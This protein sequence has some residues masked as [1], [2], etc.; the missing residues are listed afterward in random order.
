VHALSGDTK[1]TLF[2][3]A[4]STATAT[5]TLFTVT[6][7]GNVGIGTS[8]PSS[9][10]SLQATLPTIS[11]YDSGSNTNDTIFNTSGQ[12]AFNA[13]SLNS[14]AFQQGGL[15]R[16]RIAVGG[17][18][19]IGT[20]SPKSKL[21]VNGDI[22]TDGLPP[23][24]SGCGTLP[25]TTVGDTDTAGMVTEGTIATGCTITFNVAKTNIPFCTVVDQSGLVFSY[26]VSGTA[27]VVT[28]VGALSGTVLNYQCVQ[29]NL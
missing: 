3:I 25:T 27:I 13:G 11:L 17:N 1:T 26:T 18:V 20:T 24:V 7:A 22:G 29:N 19:G 5:T 9:L 16:M 8:T 23:V 28:N 6:N 4:S 14:I 2:A 15:E 12:L 21:T 10:L